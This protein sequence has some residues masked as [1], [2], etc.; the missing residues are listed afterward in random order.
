MLVEDN[1]HNSLGDMGALLNITKSTIYRIITEDLHLH[2]V[3]AIWVPHE[4]SLEPREARVKGCK[5]IK[6]GCR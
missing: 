4:L 1:P 5:V 6:K 2:S 3:T